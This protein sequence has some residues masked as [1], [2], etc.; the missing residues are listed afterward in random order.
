[1]QKADLCLVIFWINTFFIG[2]KYGCDPCFFRQGKIEQVGS[3][4]ELPSDADEILDL[5]GS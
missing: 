3:T 1:M 4:N 2:Q 5:G